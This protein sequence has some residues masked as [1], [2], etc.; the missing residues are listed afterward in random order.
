M[1]G[2][3]LDKQLLERL[4]VRNEW[5]AEH[6]MQEYRNGIDWTAIRD[7]I[8]GDSGATAAERHSLLVVGSGGLWTETRRWQ[9]GLRGHGSCSICAW[10]IGDD[11]HVLHKCTALQQ[12][13]TRNQLLGRIRRAPP[14][15]TKAGLEPLFLMGLPPAP[16]MWRPADAEAPEGA[17][18]MRVDGKT[19]GDGSGFNQDCKI[20]RRA[21]WAIVRTENRPLEGW[22]R[23]E[24]LRGAVGGWFPTVPRA[25]LQALI[26]HARHGPNAVYGGDCKHVI[27]AAQQGVP[28]RWVTSRN[29][30]ADLWRELRRLMTDEGT[31]ITAIKIAA[32]KSHASAA[33]EGDVA[34]ELW[35]G[36]DEADK[37]A[38]ELCKELVGKDQR[39]QSIATARELAGDVLARIAVAAAWNMRNKADLLEGKIKRVVKR[40]AA[41]SDGGD[42]EIVARGRGGWECTKCLKC[43]LSSIGLRKLRQSVC[44]GDVEGQIH[45]THALRETNGVRWCVKC[46]CYSTRWP[47]ELRRAC[48]QAPQSEAQHNVRRRLNAGLPPTTAMYLE[49]VAAERRESGARRNDKDATGSRS[50]QVARAASM[51]CGRYLRL[52]GG[53]LHRVATVARESGETIL[54]G[55]D[56]AIATA[57]AA[58]VPATA[59]VSI[60]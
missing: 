35:H 26:E 45:A 8:W 60:A 17:V 53:P 7:Y 27:E 30:N 15:K 6:V 5:D 42:H 52:P 40:S 41:Q 46:G 49:E 34:L 12:E 2:I 51:P 25:E 32:H 21:T 13:F 16:E 10:E 44:T 58:A 22:R 28:K 24:G 50:G 11:E 43:G 39:T 18:A 29:V 14:Q 9:A 59:S 56:E 47:R 4:C 1:G 31:N 33:D 57:A 48:K 55:A 20:T 23:S 37:Y 36:N 19:Y 3:F 38:K 54:R